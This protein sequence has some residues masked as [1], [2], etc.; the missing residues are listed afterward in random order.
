M[1]KG[2][3]NFTG[4]IVSDWGATHS[5]AASIQAGLDIQMPNDSFFNEKAIQASRAGAQG[6]PLSAAP[7]RNDPAA[8]L[9]VSQQLTGWLDG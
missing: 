8:C 5:T 7:G 9:R 2:Y 4:F 6:R 1:M 3:F